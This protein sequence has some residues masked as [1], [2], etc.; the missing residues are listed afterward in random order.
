MSILQPC[1]RTL[2]EKPPPLPPSCA[3]TGAYPTAGLGARAWPPPPPPK[4][5]RQPGAERASA[6]GPG[7]VG[8]GE[9][10]GAGWAK[11]PAGAERSRGEA[12]RRVRGAARR[13]IRR[14][15][16]AAGLWDAA[17]SGGR[18]VNLKC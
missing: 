13:L 1:E 2:T 11:G 16:A 7:G 4:W 8:D 17:A 15:S 5:N 12:G 9:G 3:C 14:W 6:E 18:R 10:D